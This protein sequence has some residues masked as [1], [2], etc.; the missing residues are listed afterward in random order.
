MVGSRCR[1]LK[2][3]Q[4][5]AEEFCPA[6][7]VAD[8][9]V[10]EHFGK[11]GEEVAVVERMQELGG[12]DNGLC[13]VEH[14]YLVLQPTEVDARLA[15]YAGV[16]LAEQRGRDV[17]EGDASLEGA[18]GET[19]QVRHHAAPQ[20]HQERVASGTSPLKGRPYGSQRVERLVVVRLAN[21]NHLRSF[22]LRHLADQRPAEAERRRVG[23]HKEPVV[24]AL[25]N[26]VRRVTTQVLAYDNLVFHFF[27]CKD[28]HYILLFSENKRVKTEK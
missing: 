13:A 20:V 9:A 23:K 27:Q 11:A 16:H 2:G 17:D 10:L 5:E 22:E 19:A 14:A 18:G 24:R 7:F 3:S 26:G 25:G 6:L 28:T 15:A 12:E 4:V 1:M 8:E 21:G